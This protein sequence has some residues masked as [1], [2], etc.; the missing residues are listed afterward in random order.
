LINASI[1]KISFP[2]WQKWTKE[3]Q[4]SLVTGDCHPANFM[5]LP[6]VPAAEAVRIVDFEMLCVGN[7]AQDLAQYMI[8]HVEPAKR[9]ACEEGHVR[10]YYKE[11]IA[12]GVDGSKYTWEQCWKDYIEGGS[13]RWIWLT[14]W[15][16]ALI[17]PKMVSF[18]NEQ[19]VS[20]C[21][22][23]GVTPENVGQARP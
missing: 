9:K 14:G 22:D 6:G 2:D 4:W 15:M 18:F 12:S 17:P 8:S 19:V 7:G 21:R 23:H 13:A 11:L 1:A 16:A 20:F 5:W 10:T 3:T